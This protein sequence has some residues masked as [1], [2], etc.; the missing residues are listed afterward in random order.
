[1]WVTFYGIWWL[2]EY[3]KAFWKAKKFEIVNYYN[4][5]EKIYRK[6]NNNNNNHNKTNKEALYTC[7]GLQY[8]YFQND[9]SIRLWRRYCTIYGQDIEKEC[10]DEYHVKSCLLI[11]NHFVLLTQPPFKY[12]TNTFSK[13]V[14]FHQKRKIVA[15]HQKSIHGSLA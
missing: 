10:G 5:I 2:W 4:W 13:I 6:R 14:A 11:H 8:L 1:M 12:R 15:F 7:S 3:S 9:L